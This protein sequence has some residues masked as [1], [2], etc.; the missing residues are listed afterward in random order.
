[1]N[2]AIGLIAPQTPYRLAAIDFVNSAVNASCCHLEE[3]V[4]K[5][6]MDTMCLDLIKM[7]EVYLSKD[8]YNA[9]LSTVGFK[10]NPI[11]EEKWSQIRDLPLSA[12]S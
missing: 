5:Q 1:M 12:V 11:D 2:E 3:L 7:R 6:K 10:L 9:L 8:E 4:K